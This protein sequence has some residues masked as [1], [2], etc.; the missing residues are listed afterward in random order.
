[1]NIFLVPQISDE[2]RDFIPGKAIGEQIR[3]IRQIIEKAREYNLKLLYYKRL[4]HYV[5]VE[6]AVLEFSSDNHK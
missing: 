1:M 2:Q 4:I 6:F 3:N 5:N